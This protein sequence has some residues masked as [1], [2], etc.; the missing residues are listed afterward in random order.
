MVIIFAG[1]YF[2]KYLYV[3]C[4]IPNK[5]FTQ[6]REVV[7]RNQLS[8]LYYILISCITVYHDCNVCATMNE[9]LMVMLYTLLLS[10][11]MARWAYL[12]NVSMI[13]CP[14][15]TSQPE[16]VLNVICVIMFAHLGEHVCVMD[17]L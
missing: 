17:M 4:N 10:I 14:N 12:N 5:N 2:I 1:T 6:L 8:A 7:I 9:Q 16:I 13:S 3:T 15:S 11:D